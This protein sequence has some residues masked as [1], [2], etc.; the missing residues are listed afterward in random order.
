MIKMIVAI[1]LL[2][3]TAGLFAQNCN[4]DFTSQFLTPVTVKFTPTVTTDSPLV[5]HSWYFGDGASVAGPIFP[6]H[7]YNPG[8]YTVKHILERH[9]GSGV[10]VCRDSATRQIVVTNPC[11]L[12][13][14]FTFQAGAGNPREILFTNISTGLS[15]SDSIRWTFGDGMSGTGLNPVHVY[16]A[17]GVYHACLR[18]QKR[19]ANGSLTNCVSEFCVNIT[20]QST[21]DINPA[22]SHHADSIN[23]RKIYFI[24]TTQV[25]N[26]NLANWTFGDGTSASTWNAT[27]EYAHPGR[28]Y[29]CLTITDGN[30]V[31]THCDSLTVEGQP[32]L[33]C[34]NIVATFYDHRDSIPFNRMTFTAAANA[35]IL[36]QVWTIRHLPAGNIVTLHVNNPSYVFNDTG[37]YR[38]C[39]RAT[40]A[41]N[42][43]KEVCKNFHISNPVPGDNVCHMELF[44]NPA[45]NVINASLNLTTPGIIHVFVNN[46][47]GVVAV[48]LNQAGIVGH[49]LVTVNIAALPAGLY[50]FKIIHEG[51]ICSGIFFK[52]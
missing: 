15:P 17:A 21:C 19:E 33:N 9:N 12:S 48:Q 11:T 27:H 13:A 10:L 34:A 44:P 40:F 51:Q 18:I 47:M 20:I 39:L 35:P 52:Q 28:Y 24:N 45:H 49:N 22:Y 26:T 46:S 43:V 14:N 6:I 8:T 23:R 36:D 5:R 30:C 3:C 38:V 31:R 32:I 4:P 42:C 29:V 50:L 2:L 1:W 7:T 41:N 25:A 16:T 37:E